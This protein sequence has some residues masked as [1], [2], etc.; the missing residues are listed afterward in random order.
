MA[1]KPFHAK[2]IHTA[3][4]RGL[5]FSEMTQL[6]K[7]LREKLESQADTGLPKI[8]KQQQ[9]K[10]GATTKFL[11]ELC[12]K[13]LIESVVMEYKYGNTICVSTQVGCSMGCVFCASGAEG[14]ARDLTSAEILG[15]VIVAGAAIRKAKNI[16]ISERVIG[17]VVLMGSGEPL[18]NMQG[19]IGF[20]R[21]INDPDEMGFSL[22][23]VSV[24]TCGLPDKMKELTD[25]GL[26]ITLCI[27]LHAPND[28]IRKQIMPVAK[29][30]SIDQVIDAARE[31]VFKTGRRVIF[32][33]ILIDGLNDR[34]EHA[35]ELAK[36]LKGLQCHVNLIPF[37]KVD[38][39]NL[40]PP[41]SQAITL[42][43]QELTNANISC[44]RR[45]LLGAD[46]EGACGQLKRRTLKGE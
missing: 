20:L 29:T 17:N 1:K 16:P 27:S 28:E 37:N 38:G 41:T 3:L 31:H 21:R 34:Q 26:S 10:D 11:F 25:L 46:I 5:E 23:N 15:Q 9:S 42:F 4:L 19:T 22:R 33:Y 2:Q 6:S 14:K 7:A 18:D 45:R 43:E 13:Q 30:Y 24:S 44:T 8:I 36:R 40:M 39:L 32:E 12:D 35:R